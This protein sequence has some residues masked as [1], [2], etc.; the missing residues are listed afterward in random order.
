MRS[1]KELTL[2]I[3]NIKSVQK[4]TKMMQMVSAAKLLQ[5]QKKLINSKLYISKLHSII[6]IIY[7][8]KLTQK[9]T[10]IK[11]DLVFILSSDRGLCGSFNSSISTFSRKH[12]NPGDRIVFL[13]RKAFDINKSKFHSENILRVE[14]SKNITLENINNLVNEINLSQ[15]DRIRLF[16]NKFHNTFLQVPTLETVKPWNRDS[17][18]IETSLIDKV[19]HIYEYDPQN[20]LFLLK[21]LLANYTT[22]ALY[23]ACLESAASENSARMVAMD[24]ANRNTKEVLYKL[25]L[26]YN[27]SRQVAI[28][29]DLIEVIGGAESL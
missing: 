27:R 29:T 11:S 19:E 6:S 28:T 2:R 26:L 23:S 7:D 12:I 3:K 5:S 13:G 17:S 10:E 9:T 15:Y 22:A 16:Y 4:T 8:Q 1:L 21:S 14:N 24:S 25:A 20:V 18:L